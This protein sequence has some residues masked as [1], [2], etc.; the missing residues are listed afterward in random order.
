MAHD[1][2]KKAAEHH[3]Q[4]STMPRAIMRL[5][6]S[7]QRR[8]MSTPLTRTTIRPRRTRSQPLTC[9]RL[10]LTNTLTEGIGQGIF[11]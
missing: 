6:M 11:G 1:T 5:L 7:M 2:H 4:P 3:E 8:R 10:R 9:R